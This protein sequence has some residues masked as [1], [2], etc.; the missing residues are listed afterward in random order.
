MAIDTRAISMEAIAW[1]GATQTSLEIVKCIAGK[2]AKSGLFERAAAGLGVSMRGPESLVPL[3]DAVAFFLSNGDNGGDWFLKA[4]VDVCTGHLLLSLPNRHRS[5]PRILSK[6]RRFNRK[7]SEMLASVAEVLVNDHALTRLVGKVV[8]LVEHLHAGILL[9]EVAGLALSLRQVERSE[10]NGPLWEAAQR[11]LAL[12]EECRDVALFENGLGEADSPE[13][14]AALV[15]FVVRDSLEAH[16]LKMQGGKAPPSVAGKEVL[17]HLP[18][19]PSLLSA[20]AAAPAKRTKKRKLDEE[21]QAPEA[22]SALP[23]FVSAV[24]SKIK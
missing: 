1:A 11:A 7:H 6:V 24:L 17:G 19:S 23:D 21:S 2:V 16:S 3:T 20:E 10:R 22:A 8:S 14:P 9:D 15:A 5:N 18:L 4:A 13:P 12:G